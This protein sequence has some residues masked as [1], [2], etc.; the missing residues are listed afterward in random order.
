MDAGSRAGLVEMN[1]SSC[2]GRARP[3][4]RNL[5]GA[6][7]NRSRYRGHQADGLYYSILILNTRLEILR[8]Y[9]KGDPSARQIKL[10]DSVI[11]RWIECVDHATRH[12][13]LIN[14]T[15]AIYHQ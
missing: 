3:K 12:F 6:A 4:V 5:S 14:K 8:L 7:R 10:F 9:E 1:R 11:R 15:A 2:H 13:Q